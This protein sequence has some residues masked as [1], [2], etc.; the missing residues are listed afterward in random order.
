MVSNCMIY[1]E[2]I[3]KSMCKKLAYFDISRLGKKDKEAVIRF[4]PSFA[5]TSFV[6]HQNII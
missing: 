5:T 4:H 3:L 1:V 6:L 2:F